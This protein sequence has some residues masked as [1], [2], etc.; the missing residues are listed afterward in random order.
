VLRRLGDPEAGIS[1][2][3]HICRDCVRVIECLP[4]LEHDP[5]RPEDVRKVDVDDDGQGGDDAYDALRY[6]LMAVADEPD[7]SQGID[8]AEFLSTWRG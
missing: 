1:P 8:L 3:L 2:T 4:S 7:L 5:H 6:G